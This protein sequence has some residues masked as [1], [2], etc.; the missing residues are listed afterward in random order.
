M[1]IYYLYQQIDYDMV[2]AVLE[3][4][5]TTFPDNPTVWLMDLATFINCNLHHVP[6]Q[7]P[8]FSGKPLGK[9]SI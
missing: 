7:D 1:T 6:E 5:Q 2:Q 3:K 8:V 4:D 9:S